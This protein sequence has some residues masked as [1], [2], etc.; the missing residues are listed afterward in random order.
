VPFAERGQRLTD[1][2]GACRV[3]WAG[4]PSSF[5]SPSVAF[6]DLWCHPRPTSPG[7]PAVLF[8]G[9]LTGRNLDRITRLGDG[10]IPIMGTTVAQLADD[11]ARLRVA[12][13][14][15]G[16]PPEALRV[17]GTLRPLPG[18]GGRPDV[19]ATLEQVPA[20]VAAGA[21]EV[22]LTLRAFVDDPDRAGPWLAD[23]GRRWAVLR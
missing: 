20:L 22:T 14:D 19:A 10:W 8:S 7:G 13:A 17:R 3:L 4:G 11:V 9:T 1:A 16:R 23:L 5:A 15:A 12:W 18:P 6:E 2:I 21:T